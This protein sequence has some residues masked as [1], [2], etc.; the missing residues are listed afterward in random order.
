MKESFFNKIFFA[1]SIFAQ[2]H[3]SYASTID[4]KTLKEE[5][6]AD[7]WQNISKA[8]FLLAAGIWLAQKQIPRLNG[9]EV[10]FENPQLTCA[11]A[12]GFL[13]IGIGGALTGA[14]QLALIAQK[15][16]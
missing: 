4:F 14:T 2:F 1:V 13:L 5:V 9:Q 7:S 16:I 15:K 12:A 11:I 3:A 10:Y 6:S 8:T